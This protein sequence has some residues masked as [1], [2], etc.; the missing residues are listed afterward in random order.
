MCLIWTAQ[1]SIL[2]PQCKTIHRGKRDGSASHSVCHQAWQSDFDPW[3]QHGRRADSYK[4]HTHTH[5]RS[6]V[7]REEEHVE[8]AHVILWGNCFDREQDLGSRKEVSTSHHIEQICH[9]T[10][11]LQLERGS[12]ITKIISFVP[13]FFILRMSCDKGLCTVRSSVA[14]HVLH[15]LYF[16]VLL[17]ELFML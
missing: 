11:C 8:H 5:T 6:Q 13:S 1:N 7:S 2:H 16:L 14:T 17:R 15:P 3:A 9:L 12:D 10:T 4:L